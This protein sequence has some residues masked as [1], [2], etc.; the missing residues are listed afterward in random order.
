MY[1]E[2]F[3]QERRDREMAHSLIADAETG[4]TRQRDKARDLEEELQRSQILVRAL[5]Q[6]PSSFR[7]EA[8]SKPARRRVYSHEE[9]AALEEERVTAIQQVKS[10][11]KQADGFKRE[12]EEERKEVNCV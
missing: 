8:D 5:Q 12:L 10:Y 6:R 9:M 3:K 2:D 1:E 4:A 7:R 11:K